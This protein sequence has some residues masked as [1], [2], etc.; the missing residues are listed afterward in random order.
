MQTRAPEADQLA[1][2]QAL[3]R[4]IAWLRQSRESSG[5][6]LSTLGALTRLESRGSLRITEL[7]ELEQLT[8]P[9]MTTLINRLE[10]AGLAQRESDP[11]DKRAVRVSITGAGIDAVRRH[12]ESRAALVLD[13]ISQ[14]SP[15][16][17]DALAAALPA[18]RS[19][20]DD[21]LQPKHDRGSNS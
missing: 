16:D 1:V 12:R 7:A 11:D 6:S 20:S 18:L 2:A 3:E 9:G 14:L 19:F 10:G 5:L 4:V 21:Q 8:Q 13:R 15:D 17:Q